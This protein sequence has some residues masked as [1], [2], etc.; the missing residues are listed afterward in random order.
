MT[1]RPRD[2]RGKAHPSDRFLPVAQATPEL[3]AQL[4]RGWSRDS[5]KKKIAQ[6]C[7]FTWI[8][9]VHYVRIHGQLRAVNVDAVLREIVTYSG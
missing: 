9:G 5:I 2:L 7:P 6:G 1:Q 3:T 4:G 8:Q